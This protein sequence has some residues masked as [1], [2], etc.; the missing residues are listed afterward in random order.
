[1]AG[2]TDDS[3][4]RMFRDKRREAAQEEDMD[5]SPGITALAAAG[6]EAMVLAN[7][8]TPEFRPSRVVLEDLPERGGVRAQGVYMRDRDDYALPELETVPNYEEANKIP[9][10]V[11][12][13]SFSLEREMSKLVYLPRFVDANVASV[14]SWERGTGIVLDLIA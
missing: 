5:K 6:T 10:R 2:W 13:I 14:S 9:D 12:G 8:N 1:M 4:G 3:S 11:L 7:M